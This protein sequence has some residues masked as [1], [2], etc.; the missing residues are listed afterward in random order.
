MGYT[1]T[2]THT[3]LRIKG[4]SALGIQVDTVQKTLSIPEEKL[5]EIKTLC[6]TWTQKQVATKQQFQSLLGSFAV[7]YKMH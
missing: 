3:P 2:L 1:Y 5:Q 6:K 4:F 7:Y